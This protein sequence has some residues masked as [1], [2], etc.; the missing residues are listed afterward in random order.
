LQH[1]ASFAL[2]VKTI[3]ETLFARRQAALAFRIGIDVGPAVGS[4]V[5]SEHRSFAFWGEAVQTAANMADTSLPGT[6]QVTESV[7]ERLRHTY[8]FQLRGHHYLA[9]VGE[10]S[11]Y[12]LGGRL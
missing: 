7:Y 2:R 3:C 6:I 8:L 1:I 9:G 11:T 4:M 10:F 5:G 12:L